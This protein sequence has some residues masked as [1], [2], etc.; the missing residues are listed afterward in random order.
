MHFEH[1]KLF[2]DIAVHRSVSK[3][4]QLNGI[5]Q[6]A[7]SQHIHELE[8]FMSIKLLDRSTRPLTITAAGRLY[9][10][11]CKD[12]LRRKEEF[13]AS[14][15]NLAGGVEGTVRV[16]SIYSVG[17]SEMTRLEEQFAMNWPEAVLQV[18]YLRPERVLESVVN[19]QCDL[20]LV[21]YPETTKELAV[22]AWRQ[23]EMVLACHPGHALANRTEIAPADL[24]GVEF[25]GFDRDLPIQREVDKYLKDHGVTAHVVMHFD[26]LNMIKEAV[27]IGSGVSIIPGRIIASEIAAGTLRGIPLKAPGLYRPLGI[28][29]RKRKKFNRATAQFL[30]LLQ[31]NPQARKAVPSGESSVNPEPALSER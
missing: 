9:S 28:V 2:R 23:E 21:S 29:H 5:S 12:I 27:T 11:L 3:G 30:A 4:A 1:F 14:L 17:L 31:Q 26:N 22:I 18:E 8:R 6:S 15:S 24:E 10:D 19:D 16:A 7:A 20:G 25:I 13:D